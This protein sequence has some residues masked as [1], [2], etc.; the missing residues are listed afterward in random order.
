[1]A[2]RCVGIPVGRS[3]IRGG[4]GGYAGVKGSCGCTIDNVGTE[5]MAIVVDMNCDWTR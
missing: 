1:M 2:A 4:T 5:R 3:E